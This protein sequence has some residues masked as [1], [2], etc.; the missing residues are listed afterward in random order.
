MK[1]YERK[2]L[3]KDEKDIPDLS[4]I[5]HILYE[6]YFMYIG[7]DG[8]VRVQK[9]G[10]KYEIESVFGEYRKK[11]KITRQAFEKLSRNCERVIK[12]ETYPLGNGMKIKKYLGQYSGLYIVDIEFS[13]REQFYRFKKPDWLGCEI[14][15]TVLGKDGQI[16][17][18]SPQKVFSI[19]DSLN[20]DEDQK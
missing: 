11:I 7:Q 1:T 5:E 17:L 6:R 13:D 9:R 19:L 8:Q 16:I 12:R 10:E 20:K 18:L 2:F 15:S 4:N 3:V 14:T